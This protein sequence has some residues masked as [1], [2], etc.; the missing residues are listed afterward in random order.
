L[1]FAKSTNKKVYLVVMAEQLFQI[2]AK[3]L[4]RNNDGAI[5]M[6][7]VPPWDNVPDHWDLPG[8]RMDL[9]ETFIQTL[10]REID[11]ELGVKLSGSP[12][13][14][15]GMLTNILIPVGGDRYPLVYII[16]EV[17]IENPDN[18]QLSNETR[19]FEFKW[20]APKDA[21][22]AMAHKFDKNFCEYISSL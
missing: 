10:R 14:I 22:M 11:E 13:Q 7:H 17:E 1:N 20:L 19:E 5:F 6:L 21:A 16:F 15:M 18:I 3:A 9:G 12:R 4:I 8:G 2:A